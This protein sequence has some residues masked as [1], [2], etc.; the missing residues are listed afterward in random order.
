MGPEEAQSINDGVRSTT[1]DAVD[2][3]LS[4]NATT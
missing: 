3:V 2:P 1:D 4:G